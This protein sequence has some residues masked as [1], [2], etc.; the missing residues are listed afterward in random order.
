VLTRCGA[1]GVAAALPLQ[2]FDFVTMSWGLTEVKAKGNWTNGIKTT[3]A[4]LIAS[5]VFNHIWLLVN[6]DHT[7]ED[8]A[9][10]ASK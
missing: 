4:G 7:A 9:I 5:L 2:A 1:L 3:T 8:T 6:A 10:M